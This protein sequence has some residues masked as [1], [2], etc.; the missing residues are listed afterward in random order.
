MTIKTEVEARPALTKQRLAR[1]VGRRTRLSNKAAD[2][3]LEAVIAI[4]SEQ[5]AAGGRV[6]I[7]N[8][9]TLTVKAHKRIAIE[10]NF[11]NNSISNENIYFV[12]H[13]KPGKRLHAQLRALT[14]T[15]SPG[16]GE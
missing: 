4:I 10:R 1:E 12:L 8:F 7:A 14:A 15:Q 13:C 11:C 2:S 16:S 6:E 5:L 9:L 3:A